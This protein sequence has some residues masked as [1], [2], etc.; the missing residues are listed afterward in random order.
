MERFSAYLIVAVL[1]IPGSAGAQTIANLPAASSV[2]SSDLAAVS[3]SGVSR[4][5]T[6]GQVQSL[7]IDNCQQC[8]TTPIIGAQP[9][10]LPIQFFQFFGPTNVADQT[11]LARNGAVLMWNTGFSYQNDIFNL[12]D[13]PAYRIFQ[14]PTVN[15]TGSILA[16]MYANH[17][18]WIVY[19]TDQVTP[20][21]EFGNTTFPPFDI[22]NP[23]AQAFVVGQILGS[24]A[25]AQGVALDNVVVF[26]NYA[27]AGHYTN[28]TDIPCS[29]GQQPACGG[30]WHQDT[31]CT[32]A[33]I[34]ANG[35]CFS[36]AIWP[37]INLAWL[38]YLRLHVGTAGYAIVGNNTINT[39]AGVAANWVIAAQTMNGVMMQGVP[40]NC[41]VGGCTA[42]KANST[43]PNGFIID[44][45][46]QDALYAAENLSNGQGYLITS[47]LNG[48]DTSA[49]TQQE[50]EYAVAWDLLTTVSP[51]TT[52]LF[53]GQDGSRA[54]EP[55]PHNM[56]GYI[57]IA[58]T[59]TT[60]AAS[61]TITAIPSTTGVGIGDAIAGGP[62]IP[63]GDYVSNVLGSTS[64]LLALPATSACTATPIQITGLG[65]MPMGFPL[66]PPPPVQ[67]A[68]T[69][70]T[71]PVL[72]YRQY[73][74]GGVVM[75]PFCQIVSGACSASAQTFTLPPVIGSGH[76]WDLFC[77]ELTTS[78][79]SIAPATSLV[80]ADGAHCPFP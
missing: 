1:L 65:R 52:Y 3:Q 54:I 69:P 38:Q 17:P 47:Q 2:S 75:N 35:N 7:V 15:F 42:A 24:V 80:F 63:P 45:L 77:N 62:C 25:G 41:D 20:A 66:T 44:G 70:P 16:W 73:S 64:L 51:G 28:V 26:N 14:P 27:E 59:A 72:Y 12:S 56:G 10:N 55:Y 50:E 39:S 46:F 32:A 43:D 30:V 23:A 5:A 19:T 8:L 11:A 76:W 36:D 31:Q 79:V 33:F 60:A 68:V 74:N 6:L 18:D 13:Q 58:T 4:S 21:W 57:D 67:P 53:A 78:T 71:T 34:A 61:T 49:I 37:V 29:S 48:H 9:R 40:Q 22:T